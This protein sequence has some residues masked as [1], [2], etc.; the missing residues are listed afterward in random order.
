MR[1][2]TSIKNLHI[3]LLVWPLAL[4]ALYFMNPHGSGPSLCPLK[5]LGV[6][7]CPGCGLGHAI[8]Y[9][10]H[11]NW[12]ASWNSHPMGAFALIVLLYRTFDLARQ[13]FRNSSYL[14]NNPI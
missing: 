13:A 14:K 3:E 11:G 5:W 12:R 10:L 1:L 9:L 4:T 2:I 8:H 6:P 7:W